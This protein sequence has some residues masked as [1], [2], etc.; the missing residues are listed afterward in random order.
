M[1]LRSPR[2][3]YINNTKVSISFSRNPRPR[4]H[5]RFMLPVETCGTI[6]SFLPSSYLSPPPSQFR[7]W[8]ISKTIIR[9]AK[10][11]RV[12]FLTPYFN[13][14]FNEACI[15]ISLFFNW[16]Y[17]YGR[18]RFLY[19][20]CGKQQ[21]RVRSETGDSLYGFTPILKNIL[22]NYLSATKIYQLC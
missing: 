7:S 8:K 11:L 13:D 15:P 3:C 5:G 9:R 6:R 14:H 4:S 10:A 20:R 17:R 22:S 19:S 16:L 12:N 2:V 1:Y 18:A 21:H